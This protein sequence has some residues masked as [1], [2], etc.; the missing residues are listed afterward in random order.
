M[1]IDHFKK[2]NDTHGHAVGDQVLIVFTRTLQGTVG[3]AGTVFRYGGEEFAIVCPATDRKAA[4]SLAEACRAAIQN[5]A[6][7][8]TEDGQELSITCSI[9]VAC[10]DG[11]FFASSAQLVKAADQGVYAAK[12]AGRNAVRVFTPRRKS[13]A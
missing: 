5:D 10:H 8:T 2:F 3:D 11:R 7:L 12:D 9:G 1:D 13:A 6:R 4:A